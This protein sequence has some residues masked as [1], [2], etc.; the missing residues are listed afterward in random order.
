MEISEIKEKLA[1]ATVRLKNREAE[2]NNRVTAEY[3]SNKS[4]N[5]GQKATVLESAVKI[6]WA[7]FKK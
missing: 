2:Q 3:Y 7:I 6:I 4:N 1:M 5:S